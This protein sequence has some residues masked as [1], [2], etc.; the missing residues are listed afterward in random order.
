MTIG[1]EPNMNYAFSPV[2]IVISQLVLF[3]IYLLLFPCVIVC[4]ESF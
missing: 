2:T 1:I 4:D 3:Q